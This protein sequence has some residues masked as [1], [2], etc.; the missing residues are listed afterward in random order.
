MYITYII[1]QHSRSILQHS[2]ILAHY[3]HSIAQSQHSHSY[4][5][6]AQYLKIVLNNQLTQADQNKQNSDT[7]PIINK[8]SS[9]A[10]FFQVIV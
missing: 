6:I 7:W 3:L 4:Y 1:Y 10:C 5:S 9:D 2:T 8:Q